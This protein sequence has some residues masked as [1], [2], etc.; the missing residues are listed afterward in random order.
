[1]AKDVKIVIP[2]LIYNKIMHWIK[3]AG[4]YEVS[5][6]GKLKV[7]D[8][9]YHIVDAW[10]AEQKNTGGTTDMEPASVAKLMYT[11]REVEGYLNWWWHSHASMGVFWSS[12]DAATIKEL[13]D[14]GFIVATVFNNKGEKKSCISF[15]GDGIRPKFTQDD[16]ITEIEQPVQDAALARAWSD[17]YEANV[18]KPVP[19]VTSHYTG[20]TRG[21]YGNEHYGYGRNAGIFGAETNDDFYGDGYWAGGVWHEPSSKKKGGDVRLVDP[22]E[23]YNEMMD[24][25]TKLLKMEHESSVSRIPT[26][27]LFDV[28]Q[29]YAVKH[30]KLVQYW[31]E[32]NKYYEEEYIPTMEARAK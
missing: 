24:N 15:A 12:T 31:Y 25:P 27:D 6:M 19:V 28:A 13:S 23:R 4:S 32:L 22:I 9:S 8:G 1:M 26:A 14:N 7:V 3:Q 21:R 11:T 18:K 5:G 30:D 2:L 17:E 20:H 10:L 16:I 29:M